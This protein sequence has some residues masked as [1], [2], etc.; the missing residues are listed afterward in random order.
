[1]KLELAD[2]EA[3]EAFGRQL[4]ACLAPD[5]VVF[6]QGDLGAGKTTLVR[7]ILRGLGHAGAVKSP[8]YTLVEPY[9]LPKGRCDHMDLYRLADPGELEYLGVRDLVGAGHLLLVEWPEKAEAALP[10]PDLRIRI[11]HA[12]R[13]RVLH[14]DAT[15]SKGAEILARF[16]HPV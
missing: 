4:A 15:S 12:R 14:L 2:A 3:Q 10:A 13:G 6:L 8:T 7:G 5:A 11:E 16:D 1:M 9:E